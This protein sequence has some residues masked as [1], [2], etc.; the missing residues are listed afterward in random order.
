M[1]SI[2]D[3][4]KKFK[5]QRVSKDDEEL[6]LIPNSPFYVVVK[7]GPVFRVRIGVDWDKMEEIAQEMIDEG[8]DKEDV[9]DVMDDLLDEALKIAYDVIKSLEREGK[10]VKSELTSSIMDIKDEMIDRLEYLEE[11]S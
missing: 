2:S 3:A 1:T 8:E 7:K 4:A 5:L 6:L 9:L 10:E 11:V